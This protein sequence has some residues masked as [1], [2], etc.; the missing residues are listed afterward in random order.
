M[1]PGARGRRLIKGLAALAILGFVAIA[2]LLGLLRVER[3]TEITL[4]APTGRFAVG[5][6]MRVWS[7]TAQTDGWAPSPGERRELVG[8]I[9]Y[10]AA[11]GKSNGGQSSPAAPYLPAPWRAALA[12]HQGTL[13]EF[14]NRDLSL[15]HAHSAGDA[16]VSAE[17]R[18]Y[19]VVIMRP[20]LGALTTDFTTLAEDLAS[21]GY[22]VVGFDAPYRT[23]LVVFPDGRVVTRPPANN[24]E[25][26][27]GGEQEGLADRLLAAWCADTRFVLDQLERL[28]AADPSGNLTGR[29]DLQSVGVFGHSLGGATAAQ[30]CH[31]DPRCKGG[32]DLDGAP[33]GSVVRESLSR[34][35]MFILSDHGSPSNPENRRILG[36]I[37]SIYD[38]LPD[39]RRLLMT[40]RGAHHF[41]FSDQALLKSQHLMRALGMLGVLGSLD[42]R[43]GLA[44]TADYLHRFFDVYLEG[45]PPVL[46]KDPSRRY[47]EVRLGYQP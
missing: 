24:P 29:L 40:I 3:M 10:P 41:S 22:V 16:A 45:A 14:L 43:R 35:F 4:P 5:R 39:G 25:T 17:R 2:A 42:A 18:K 32:I 37:Q 1:S 15:V 28:D 13:G 31:D 26:L 12:R 33:R 44:I 46:L 34:P 11:G 20:G 6:A 21:H 47:P 8:W 38:R 9:W 7:D 27:R 30:F 23:G 36:D 19:P